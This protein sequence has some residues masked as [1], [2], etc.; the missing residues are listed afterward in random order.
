MKIIFSVLVI[1]VFA[2]AAF[3]QE[4][5]AEKDSSCFVIRKINYPILKRV[6]PKQKQEKRIALLDVCPSNPTTIARPMIEIERNGEKQNRVF[7]VAKVFKNKAEAR[8]YAKEN[9]I[10]DVKFE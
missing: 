9:N 7:D 4:R 6:P 5:Q 1:F 10:T 2:I 8:K 3:G